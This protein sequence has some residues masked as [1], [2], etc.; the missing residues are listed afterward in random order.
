MIDKTEPTTAALIVRLKSGEYN[1]VDIMKAWIALRRLDEAEAT[2][3]AARELIDRWNGEDGEYLGA[4]D[5]A[6]E[7]LKLLEKANE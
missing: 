1:G 5:C 4:D 3:K 2:I 6:D 7:L